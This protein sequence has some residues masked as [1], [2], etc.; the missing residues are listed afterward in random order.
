MSKW[1]LQ[2][3]QLL[4]RDFAAVGIACIDL[5]PASAGSDKNLY[6]PRNTHGNI[7]GNLVAARNIIP[8]VI[9]II[10]QGSTAALSGTKPA[11]AGVRGA[12]DQA[13]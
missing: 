13:P 2:P 3:N 4:S 6:K 5:L 12:G 9:E 7:A 8:K 10:Q 1:M 11:A